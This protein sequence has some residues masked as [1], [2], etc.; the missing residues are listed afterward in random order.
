MQINLK[1]PEIVEALKLYIKNKGIDL[2][3]KTVKIDFTAGRKGT[4][5]S[6]DIGI[7]YIDIPGTDVADDDTSKTTFLKVVPVINFIE[8]EATAMFVSSKTAEAAVEKPPV[9]SLFSG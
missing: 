5:L 2:V 9:S 8:P 1:E 6:A 4:G 3:G 7:E